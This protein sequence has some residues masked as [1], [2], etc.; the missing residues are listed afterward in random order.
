MNLERLM[1]L[2]ATLTS[3]DVSTSVVDEYGNPAETET[4]TEVRCWVAPSSSSEDTDRTNRQSEEWN[5]YF[6]PSLDLNGWDRLTLGTATYEFD[7]PPQTYTHPRS[8]R[9]T[10]TV[11]RLRRVV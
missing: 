9:P 5:G 11:A 4:S 10:Y 8:T 7:G 1:N 2:A 6:P 3:A